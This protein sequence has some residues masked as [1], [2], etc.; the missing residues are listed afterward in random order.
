M[1][2]EDLTDQQVRENMFFFADVEI[3][4][5]EEQLLDCG[6]DNTYNGKV[7]VVSDFR[8]DGGYILQLRNGEIVAVEKGMIDEY[9]EDDISDEYSRAMAEAYGE[10]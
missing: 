4:A 8:K 7:G 6:L 10:V 5:T 1:K 3:K 9:A 2:F